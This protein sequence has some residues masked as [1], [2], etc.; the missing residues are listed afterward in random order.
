MKTIMLSIFHLSMTICKAYCQSEKTGNC[1]QL[2]DGYILRVFETCG[3]YERCR[4]DVFFCTNLPKIE[5]CKRDFYLNDFVIGNQYYLFNEHA[6][7]FFNMIHDYYSDN[8]KAYYLSGISDS[9]IN[10]EYKVYVYKVTVC[11]TLTR[12]TDEYLNSRT[13]HSYS[14]F[15]AGHDS[16]T[17]LTAKIVINR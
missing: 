14:G 2:Y 13:S 4:S 3:Q 8:Y 1:L 12:N 6:Y 11:G 10:D 5:Q 9:L 15:L 16:T 7:D 17:V